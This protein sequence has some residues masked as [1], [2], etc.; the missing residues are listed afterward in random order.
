MNLWNLP[1]VG[2]PDSPE[3][4]THMTDGLRT[5]RS[6]R[7]VFG[8]LL[9]AVGVLVPLAFIVWYS[10]VHW[11]LVDNPLRLVPGHVEVEFT[12]NFEGH[13]AAGINVQRR[14]PFETLQCLL[15]EKNYVPASQCKDLPAVLQFKWRLNADGRV[16]EQGTSDQNFHGAY[17]NDFIEMEFLYFEAKRRQTYRLE[18]EFMKIG[19]ELAV[20]NPRLRVGVS[21][22]DSSDTAMGLGWA[23]LVAAVCIAPGIR[24]IRARPRP[25]G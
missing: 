11:V 22:W 1:M 25:V 18:I 9:A 3:K 15:G 21:S 4:R 6:S 16:V 19:A 17:G 5:W 23:L 2:C 12:P 20:T 13:Y 8:L 7:A 24:L 10:H 14:L